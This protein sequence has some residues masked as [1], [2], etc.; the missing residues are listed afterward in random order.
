M[1]TEQVEHEWNTEQWEGGPEGRLRLEREVKKEIEANPQ[2]IMVCTEWKRREMDLGKRFRRERDG[3][4]AKFNKEL[5][6]KAKET[7]MMEQKQ[8][9]LESESRKL[10]TE[11]DK[12]ILIEL[13]SFYEEE[14]KALVGAGLSLLSTHPKARKE[15][16]EWEWMRMVCATIKLDYSI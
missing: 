3:L 5:S 7:N 16:N 15:L 11:F 14:R 2:I 1:P 12:N 10:L 4:V 8:K 6:L 13:R 9:T